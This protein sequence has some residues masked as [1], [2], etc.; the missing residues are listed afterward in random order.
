VCQ[1]SNLNLRF[2]GDAFPALAA[3]PE[4]FEQIT[5]F[6]YVAGIWRENLH[7]GLLWYASNALSKAR[8]K[9]IA[10]LWSWAS[11]GGPVAMMFPPHARMRVAGLR[12]EIINLA[13]VGGENK[14]M[15]FREATVQ[16]R[17]HGIKVWCRSSAVGNAPYG[18]PYL[19]MAIDIIDEDRIFVGKGRL[20]A[21]PDQSPFSC[22]ALVICCDNH[23]GNV[24]GQPD[25]TYLLLVQVE[26]E[27]ADSSSKRIGVGRT[28]DD[29]H[30]S[31]GKALKTHEKDLFLLV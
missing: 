13:C 16:L 9:D 22:V 31:H 14:F 11:H 23:N 10:P 1:Y 17:A 8:Y 28:M 4:K 6:S 12:A 24:K 2:I 27:S 5:H 18:D 30:G 20:D 25:T 26:K 19:R 29:T 7:R 3:I 15:V 21:V